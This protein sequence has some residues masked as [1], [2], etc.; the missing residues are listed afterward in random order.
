MTV[1][2]ITAY[3]ITEEFET[4]GMYSS[5]LIGYKLSISDNTSLLIKVNG[6]STLLKNEEF[7]ETYSSKEEVSVQDM[8]KSG[9]HR[10]MF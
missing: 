8:V 9:I 5:H 10:Y 7:H 2:R 3:T 6:E 1:L 4:N